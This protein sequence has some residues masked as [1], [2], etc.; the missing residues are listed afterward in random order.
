MVITYRTSIIIYILCL[1]L[2]SN[3][4]AGEN[5]WGYSIR[6]HT[7]F[8]GSSDCFFTGTDRENSPHA[9][10][11]WAGGG[12]DWNFF[13]SPPP[14]LGG[15]EIRDISGGEFPPN[16]GEKINTG[17]GSRPTMRVG[18]RFLPE[19]R[20]GCQHFKNDFK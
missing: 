13:H 10:P 2:F 16:L 18:T 20:W 1:L 5:F 14:S 15:G 6:I 12:G 17:I 11:V 7:K 8:F 9:P 4:P 19:G 3:C